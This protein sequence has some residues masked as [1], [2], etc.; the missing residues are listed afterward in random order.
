MPLLLCSLI[1]MQMRKQ[2][3][4]WE[5]QPGW[6]G[7]APPKPGLRTRS[8]SGRQRMFMIRVA[9][10]QAFRLCSKIN[11]WQEVRH[12]KFQHGLPHIGLQHVVIGADA[13]AGVV[14][15]VQSTLGKEAEKGSVMEVPSSSS[16]DHKLIPWLYSTF[17][18]PNTAG[19]YSTIKSPVDLA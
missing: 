10:S 14:S 15:V 2:V 13:G 12:L 11:K 5:G 18:W 16:G 8:R 3:Q 6:K 9:F 7:P 1:Y 19:V 17:Y 4:R